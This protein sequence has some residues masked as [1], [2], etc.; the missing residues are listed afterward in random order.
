M[1]LTRAQLRGRKGS[2]TGHRFVS[3]SHH[4]RCG[5]RVYIRIKG[6]PTVTRRFVDLE[7]ALALRDEK[8]REWGVLD[9]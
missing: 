7:A 5:F 2:T 9:E 3:R 1:K 6:Y 4:G 8:L